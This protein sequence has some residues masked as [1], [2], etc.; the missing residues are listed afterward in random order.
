MSP[1]ELAGAINRA[2]EVRVWV[3][4]SAL[5]GVLDVRVEK[6]DARAIVDAAREEIKEEPENPYAGQVIASLENG[7]LLIGAVGDEEDEDDEDDED[8]DEDEEE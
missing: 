8:D 5:N 3:G 4:W 6:K 7:V 2:R 1:R